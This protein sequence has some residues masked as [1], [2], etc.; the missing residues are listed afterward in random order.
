MTDRGKPHVLKRRFE[1]DQ[2]ELILSPTQGEARRSSHAAGSRPIRLPAPRR[3]P[4]LG[5]FRR[6]LATVE[7]EH[8]PELTD[9]ELSFTRDESETNCAEVRKQLTA[10]RLTQ[11]FV[12]RGAIALRKN[13]EGA[14]ENS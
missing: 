3:R 9:E 2:G 5:E 6:V 1:S 4:G 10:P 11:A 8:F 13:R 12:P 14:A 7:A